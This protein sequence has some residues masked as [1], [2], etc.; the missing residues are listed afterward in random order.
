MGALVG[1][2]CDSDARATVLG[3]FVRA[4]ALIRAFHSDYGVY[5]DCANCSCKERGTELFLNGIGEPASPIVNF[6]VDHIAVCL[7]HEGV[8]HLGSFVERISEVV[9]VVAILVSIQAYV[10]ILEFRFTLNVNRCHFRYL[11]TEQAKRV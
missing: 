11:K 3:S 10:S 2:L 7:S 8:K 4:A 9:R 1:G 5:R 6:D